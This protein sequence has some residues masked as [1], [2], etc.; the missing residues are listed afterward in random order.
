MTKKKTFASRM[1]FPQLAHTITTLYV[2]AHSNTDGKR[3]FSVC[4][5]IDTDAWSQLSN[6]SLHVLLSRKINLNEP[7]YAFQPDIDLLNGQSL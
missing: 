6:N 2:I 7:R 1:R 3:V 4:R 5:K